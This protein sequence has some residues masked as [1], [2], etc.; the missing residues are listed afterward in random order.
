M[1]KL[2]GTN[3]NQVPSNADLGSAAFKDVTDFLT[4]KGSNL[5]AIDAVISKSAEYVF[6]YD[7][8]NDS[9]NGA[10]RKKVSHTSWYN[11]PLNTY[12]RGSRRDFPSVAVIA[13][14]ADR[15][16]IYDADDPN[17]SFWMKFEIGPDAQ[18]SKMWRGW[19]GV[20]GTCTHALNGKVLL[21]GNAAG[22]FVIDFVNDKAT[23][24]YVNTT[25]SGTRPNI[26]ERNRLYSYTNNDGTQDIVSQEIYCVDMKVLPGADVDTVT[27]LPIPTIAVGTN[28]GASVVHSNGTVVDLQNVYLV[29]QIKFTDDNQ[30]WTA[31]TVGAYTDGM[32][33]NPIPRADVGLT[34]DIVSSLLT[35]QW[36]SGRQL[37]GPIDAESMVTFNNYLALGSNYDGPTSGVTL[38]TN[39]ADRI[40]GVIGE[41]REDALSARITS[42][43]NSGWHVGKIKA[44]LLADTVAGNLN[45]DNYAENW[46]TPGAWTKQPSITITESGGQLSIAGNGSGS[47]VYFYYPITLKAN[48][49]YVF[50]IRLTASYTTPGWYINTSA[51]STSNQYGNLGNNSGQISFNT[52]SVTTFYVQSY[53]VNATATLV[54][55]ITVR[56]AVSDRTVYRIHAQPSGNIKR[57]PVAAGAELVGFSGFSDNNANGIWQQHTDEL[58]FGTGDFTVMGWLKNS[59]D[60]VDYAVGW[61]S[62][63]AS[64]TANPRWGIRAGASTSNGIAFNINGSIVCDTTLAAREF[65][66]FV[67]FTRV[68][69]KLHG[70]VNDKLMNT[71][72]DNTSLT[73]T[74]GILRLGNWTTGSYSFSG[75]LALWR[76]SASAINGEVIKKIY[77]EEKMLFM[78]NAK[79]TLYGNSDVVKALAY[80][81]GED[82]LHI[83]TS[84][85]R[86]VFSGLT[87]VDNTTRAVDKS[88]S[89]VNGFVVE[90]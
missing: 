85:G 70:Y 81:S 71:V 56:E 52:G 43:F 67:C 55:S 41:Q 8:S 74:T 76:V 38:Y 77:E 32:Y 33:L 25:N 26:A 48:T 58:N 44:S 31:S 12:E 45:T 89:A 90:E 63:F 30:I 34:T 15:A 11:E 39:S 68:D 51:Y 24:H 7:T 65:W 59:V 3:P 49:D 73:G 42:D 84:D 83:G 1:S 72:T 19:N 37:S 36:S 75:S 22:L 23:L 6:I 20:E 66:Q 18:D 87:R 79:C 69:G 17:L 47:N 10:W 86:S 5:S 27:G 13:I 16:E 9:D 4:T 88:I 53:Q 29:R 21:C 64:A 60:T 57:T 35:N 61:N 62:N 2:I 82:S 28:I 40:G 14:F 50:D 80:D 54:D 78:D 46:A